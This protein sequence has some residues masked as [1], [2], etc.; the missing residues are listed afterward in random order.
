MK[1]YIENLRARRHVW[2]LIVIS[3]LLSVYIPV[4]AAS[5]LITYSVSGRVID[6]ETREGVAYAAVIVVGM[7]GVGCSQI[8]Q[9][10]F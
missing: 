10:S 2:P 8:P 3:V 9:D 4:D 1:S 5:Q 7:E 6:R